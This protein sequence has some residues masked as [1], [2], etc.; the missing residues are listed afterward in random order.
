MWTVGSWIVKYHKV[1]E[2]EELEHDLEI[3]SN[4]EYQD[5][6][7]YNFETNRYETEEQAERRA[8]ARIAAANDTSALYFVVVVVVERRRQALAA[9]EIAMWTE[10]VAGDP[11]STNPAAL[12]VRYFPL[13]AVMEALKARHD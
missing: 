13:A 10:R 2:E 8:A 11:D 6:D 12:A 1:Q 9:A 3:F 4:P 7:R 5:T